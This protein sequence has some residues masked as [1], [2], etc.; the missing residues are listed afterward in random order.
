VSVV[1]EVQIGPNVRSTVRVDG[2]PG[3]A[4]GVFRVGQVVDGKG[5]GVSASQTRPSAPLFSLSTLL[6][7]GLR[8]SG[9]TIQVAGMA[10]HH[11]LLLVGI[12]VWNVV[13]FSL[14]AGHDLS[15]KVLEHMDDYA[16]QR[17]RILAPWLERHEDVKELP[18]DC[19]MN[20]EPKQL[21]AETKAPV[22][23]KKQR[24]KVVS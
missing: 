2:V 4:A 16:A 21:E 10:L 6:V 24:E 15:G 8:V 13:H 1:H 18:A 3:S 20:E 17:A 9:F 14:Q 23:P 12:C 7:I 22:L 11:G 19:E 5:I